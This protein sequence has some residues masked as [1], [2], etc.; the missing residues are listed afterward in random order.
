MS[1]WGAF[2]KLFPAVKPAQP[3][4][5][6]VIPSAYYKRSPD[7]VP[8]DKYIPASDLDSINDQQNRR[9]FAFFQWA[10]MVVEV[11]DILGNHVAMRM[12]QAEAN[13]DFIQPNLARVK[14]VS[15][16][17]AWEGALTHL[18]MDLWTPVEGARAV[19][20]MAKDSL[21]WAK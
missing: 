14:V 3:K 7:Y 2:R 9:N 16:A 12:E 20:S 11:S 18:H 10:G 17:P 1:L 15:I 21:A 6:P 8:F 4:L 13:A 5:E 19:I